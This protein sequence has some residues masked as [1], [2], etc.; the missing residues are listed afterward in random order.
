MN[1][2]QTGGSQPAP[3]HV[4][5]LARLEPEPEEQDW[6]WPGQIVGCSAVFAMPTCIALLDFGLYRKSVAESMTLAAVADM[7]GN[8]SAVEVVSA[9]G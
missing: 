1:P 9:A 8:M 6:R 3:H 2:G 7:L 5:R 4:L